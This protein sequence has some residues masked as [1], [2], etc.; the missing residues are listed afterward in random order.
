MCRLHMCTHPIPFWGEQETQTGGCLWGESGHGKAL[1]FL[2]N[3]FKIVL[4]IVYMILFKKNRLSGD[5]SGGPVVKNPPSNA[6]GM[7][8]IPG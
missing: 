2:V 1:L 3:L 6:K 5:F 7:H 8:S 4:T